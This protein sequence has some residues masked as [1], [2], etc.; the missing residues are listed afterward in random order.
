M[1]TKTNSEQKPSELG[2]RMPA[3]WELHEATWLAWP[4]DQKTWPDQ[5]DEIEAAYI[6]IID[7]LHVGEVVRILVDNA[8]AEEEAAQKLKARGINR[9]V[10]FHKIETDS[11]W[12]RDYGPIFITREGGT[13]SSTNWLFNVWGGKYHYSKDK[14][15]ASK[16]AQALNIKPFE[17]DLILEGGSIDVNGQGTLLTTEECLLNPNRNPH[18][19][20]KQIEQYLKDFLNVK[21]IIWL[22]KGIEG[23]DTDGHIDEVARFVSADKIVVSV[24][25]DP[26]SYNHQVLTDNW[27]RLEQETNQE[28]KKFQLTQ[29]PMPTQ[30]K[31]GKLTLPGSY[32]NFYI[33]NACVLTPI[34]GDQ[35]DTRA[36]GILKD[37]F[38]TRKVV[39]IPA[40]P[41]IYGQ[42]A[43]H[44]MTQQEPSHAA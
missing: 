26:N 4:H 16:L 29:L 11:I 39:G 28:G 33:G 3:E 34:F 24:S 5:L 32:T 9:N 36:L 20:R 2:Y 14:Q 22:G 35:N 21:K 43:I 8:Q 42:G 15:V 31:T 23:D 19:K 44:C 18:L 40:I 30:I 1:P 27:K 6:E 38:P 17:A 12:I 25:Q 13:L 10:T 37:L 41:L 7:Y